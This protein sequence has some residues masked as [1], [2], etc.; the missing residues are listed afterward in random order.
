LKSEST[1]PAKALA[2]PKRGDIFWAKLPAI[3]SVGS[4]QR[5][6]RPVVVMSEVMVVSIDEIN[7]QVPICVI[8]PLTN[9]LEKENRKNRIRIPANF[10]VDEPGTKGS[11]GDSLA[12]TEQIRCISVERLDRKRVAYLKPTARNAVEG[13]IKYVLRIP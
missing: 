3:E 6:D 9:A 1:K 4:E 11:P 8:V 13:G 5:D 7:D 2:Q 10:K 12:L